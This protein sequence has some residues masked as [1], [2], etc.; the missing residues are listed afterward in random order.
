MS[1]AIAICSVRVVKIIDRYISG[2]ILTT[3]IWTVC[4]LSLMLVVANAMR[5]LLELLMTH[6]LPLSYI[7]SFIGDLL[8]FSMIYSIPWGVLLAVL[9]VFGK[10]SSENELVALRANGIGIIRICTPVFLI[11][12]GCLALCL[13][14]NL[15][16]APECERRFKE[17]AFKLASTEPLA[18]FGSDEVIDAFPNRKIYVGRK[19]GTT[20]ED[21]HIYEMNAQQVPV[22]VI[23]AKRGTLEVDKENQRILLRIYDARYEDRDESDV[24]DLRLMHYGI[25]VQEGVFPISLQELIAKAHS[26][27]RPTELTLSHLQ[28]AMEQKEGKQLTILRTEL[29]KRFSN[30]LAVITFV[31]I[32][33]PLAITAH[34]R[35]TSIGIAISIAVAF[36]YFIFIVVADN[37]KGNASLHPEI[38]VWLP[39]FIYLTLGGTLFY[40]LA[41]R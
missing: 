21:L 11:T 14:I 25:S 3:L 36:T 6:G 9:L 27:Q 13:W 23:Y 40:R 33:I 37:V 32:G 7:L 12:L 15:Y 29:S 20:L 10:L 39:N 26:S 34:R 5:Q 1:T 41:R 24:N 4:M 18:L 28:Q 8:P 17:L 2:Q 31:L 30:S 35:E 16:V 22:R 38:L 19:N